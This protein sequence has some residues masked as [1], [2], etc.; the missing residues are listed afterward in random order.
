MS[1]GK[2]STPIIKIDNYE[3]HFYT[4]LIHD[5]I[6]IESSS[7]V[8]TNEHNEQ[9]SDY[10]NSSERFNLKSIYIILYKSLFTSKHMENNH[11]V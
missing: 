9:Q 4:I 5:S 1:N 10:N 3:Y 2:H 7:R 11:L 6:C 8:W